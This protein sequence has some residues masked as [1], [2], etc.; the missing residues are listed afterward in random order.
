VPTLI[1]AILALELMILVHELGHLI[2]AKRVGI[3]VHTFAIGFGPTLASAS[4]G[5]TTYNLNLLPV[6]G[7][8]NMAGEDGEAAVADVPSERRFR[9]K[10]VGARLG[11]VCAG[12]IM[13]FLLAIVL[14]AAVAVAYGIPVTVST[15]V[16]SLLPGYPAAQA[17]LQ[18]GDIIVA[19]DGRPMHTGQQVINTI[20]ASDGRTLGLLIQRGDQRFLVH[21]KTRYDPRQRVWLTGFSPT[22]IRR[23]LGP[24]RALG[25]GALTTGQDIGAYLAALGNLIRS[26]KLLGE[27]GGP[28]TA[29]NVLGQAAHAGGETFLYFTA[30]FSIII[31]LFN[32]FPL[33]AL[34][35][36]RAAFLVVEGLRR[37]P[38]D[39]RREGYIHLVGLAL[40]LCLILAL[41]VHDIMHP[42]R[43]P[44]P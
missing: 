12:P 6:G 37:R 35:G 41:T 11:V 39:P 34:D 43:L 22:V 36:G 33:P 27:L 29:V 2:V 9:S 10:S 21:V 16:G 38:V 4:R 30:F 14:L 31:G 32:L 15:E 23:H 5:D 13:N 19:I 42:V 3:A 20:H 18:P 17:G 26:G 44:L 1:L 24:V 25:W 40:L 7:Y 8:V 28:V